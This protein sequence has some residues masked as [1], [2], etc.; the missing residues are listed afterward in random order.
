MPTNIL[1]TQHTFD[2]M[3]EHMERRLMTDD[4]QA[5]HTTPLRPSAKYFLRYANGNSDDFPTDPLDPDDEATYHYTAADMDDAPPGS[6]RASYLAWLYRRE[7]TERWLRKNAQAY[8]TPVDDTPTYEEMHAKHDLYQASLAKQLGEAVQPGQV[9]ISSDTTMWWWKLYGLLQW[10]GT[11]YLP[12]DPT[13]V[14]DYVLDQ[15]AYWYLTP[16]PYPPKVT[17][18]SRTAR[19]QRRADVWHPGDSVTVM[20]DPQSRLFIRAAADMQNGN[21]T[22]IKRHRNGMPYY[23]DADGQIYTSRDAGIAIQQITEM[24]DGLLG[25]SDDHVGYWI[26]ANAK[27]FSERGGEIDTHGNPN[28]TKVR[29]HVNDALRLIGKTCKKR[30]FDPD[31]KREAAQHYW[32]LSRVVLTAEQTVY[33]AGKPPK[34]RTIRSRLLEVA[35][36]NDGAGFQNLVPYSMLVAPGDYAIPTMREHGA[37]LAQLLKPLL[38]TG[39]RQGLGKAMRLRMGVYLAQQWRIRAS[40]GNYNQPFYVET[41]ID[42]AHIPAS[43]DS[44]L[45]DRYVRYFENT[46]DSLVDDGVAGWWHYTD[47]DAS[48]RTHNNWFDLWMKAKVEVMPPEVVM[49]HYAD[50]EPAAR[51]AIASARAAAKRQKKG[52]RV[53]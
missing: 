31:Q 47:W 21:H 12:N 5:T 16:P 53:V 23:D 52:K 37:M 6:T 1:A 19:P 17:E 30:D 27:F 33:E 25:L 29:F 48:R 22:R 15:V 43:P 39:G 20:N 49:Q 11:F 9:I 45:R 24:T 8:G 50:I 18:E 51:R 40:H 4:T 26:A 3:L 44:R 38:N 41:I 42:G 32:D 7:Q 46:L 34:T 14:P 28:M 10:G 35:E 36:E 13:R 2:E